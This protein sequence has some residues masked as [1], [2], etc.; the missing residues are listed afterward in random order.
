MI[1]IKSLDGS[2]IKTI[3]DADL[4]IARRKGYLPVRDVKPAFDE[5]THFL[6]FDH[7][8]QTATEFVRHFIAEP[9]PADV[10]GQMR[11]AFDT[12]P[13]EVRAAFRPLKAAISDALNDG[14]FEEVK[15]LIQNAD[16]PPE[17][18]KVRQAMLDMLTN[19]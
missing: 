1:T 11:A 16:V 12:L 7:E 10:R 6:V 8:E 18:E 9:I 17:H 19:V 2:V 14:Q 3:A 13:V 5:A 15:L 4:D